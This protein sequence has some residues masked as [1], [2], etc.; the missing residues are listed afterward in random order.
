[1]QSGL[2]ARIRLGLGCGRSFAARGASPAAAGRAAP[3]VRLPPSLGRV[4]EE[5]LPLLRKSLQHL[6]RGRLLGPAPVALWGAREGLAA[7]AVEADRGDEL[8]VEAL[9]RVDQVLSSHVP[10]AAAL[11]EDD[12]LRLGVDGRA[13]ACQNSGRGRGGGRGHSRRSLTH[14][15]LVRARPSQLLLGAP[16]VLEARR[17]RVDEGGR[18]GV[19]HQGAQGGLRGA[20]SGQ[21]PRRVGLAGEAAHGPRAGEAGQP[22][23][24]NGL[25]GGGLPD[26]VH[27]IAGLELPVQNAHACVV[28][29]A[30]AVHIR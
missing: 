6:L 5:L 28:Q 16:T 8:A 22:K 2:G 1:M 15:L 4:V 9:E 21:P 23:L 10:A 20:F 29:P 13:L 3:G 30:A 27:E 18:L 26:I 11:A 14:T 12:D 24:H 7:K 25:A 17:R 19:G